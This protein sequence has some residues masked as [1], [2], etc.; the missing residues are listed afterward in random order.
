MLKLIHGENTFASEVAL[1]DIIRNVDHQNIPGDSAR[2][3]SDL[4]FSS[5]NLSLFSQDQKLI[6]IRNLSKNRKKSLMNE[7]SEYITENHSVVNMVLFESVKFDARTKIFKTIK[8]YGELME[9]QVLNTADLQS[10][11]SIRLRNMGIDSYPQGTLEIIERVG[12]NQKIIDNELE[13]LRLYLASEKRSEFRQE[14]LNILT[15]NSEVVIWELLDAISSRK[16]GLIVKIIDELFQV[17]SD[18]P[19]LSTMLAKQLKLIYWMKCSKITEEEMK[20]EFKVHP[21]TIS[22]VKRYIHLFDERLIKLIYAKLTSLDFK[23]KQGRIDAKL[24][25]IM[26]FAGV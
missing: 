26:L 15:K 5:S 10:W 8:K 22:K 13:K 2:N 12:T 11:L 14:D 6:I 4:I 17:E 24:G 16:K 20:K 25:L 19:Y 21:Y 7:L 18:Y 23:V 1:K 3:I 9:C